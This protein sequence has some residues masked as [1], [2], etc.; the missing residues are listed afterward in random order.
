[1]MILRTTV[2]RCDRQGRL[3]RQT[4]WMFG[5][6]WDP[7]VLARD[8]RSNSLATFGYDAIQRKDRWLLGVAPITLLSFASVVQTEVG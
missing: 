1:M 7:V 2:V 4:I 3:V 5:A 8:H 6:D